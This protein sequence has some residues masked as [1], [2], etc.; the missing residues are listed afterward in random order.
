MAS[1]DDILAKVPSFARNDPLHWDIASIEVSL[2][3][4]DLV[5]GILQSAH[6]P[7]PPA[8]AF[9]LPPATSELLLG[10]AVLSASHGFERH[11]VDM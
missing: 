8:S 4:S 9:T 2:L 6:A 10:V 1:F 7:P 5:L 3:I 11:C